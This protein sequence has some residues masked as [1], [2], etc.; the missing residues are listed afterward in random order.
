MAEIQDPVES[1]FDDNGLIYYDRD[2][3]H[4]CRSLEMSTS[5]RFFAKVNILNNKLYNPISD[6]VMQKRGGRMSFAEREVT[7]ESFDE[8]VE[9][10]KTKNPIYYTRA[11]SS[12]R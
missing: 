7:K 11:N 1:F 6:D 5:N 4:S 12:R 8:Y 2:G 9:Y 3:G 10:L